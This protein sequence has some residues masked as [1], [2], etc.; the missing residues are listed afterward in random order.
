MIIAAICSAA[1]IVLIRPLIDDI[2]SRNNSAQLTYIAALILII[3]IIKAISEYFQ[4][5]II[6]SIGQKILTDIQMLLFDHLLHADLAFIQSE[7]SGKIISRLTN[8]INLVRGAVSNILISVARDFLTLIA[9]LII[10]ISMEP[11]LSAIVFVSFPVAI[12][13]IQFISKRM[14]QI[15]YSTQEN[16]SQYSKNLDEVFLSI[17]VVK[18]YS[19][20]EFEAKKA[21]NITDQILTLYKK[22]IKLESIISPINEIVSS[23]AITAILVYGGLSV[24]SGTST[25]GSLLTFIAA[26][27][28]AYKP[29]KSL[30]T[31]N[32]NLQEAVAASSRIFSALDTKPITYDLPNANDAEFASANICFNNIDIR[33]NDRQILQNLN[34]TIPANQITAIVG[35]SGAGKSSII[36]L[37]LKFYLPDSGQILIDDQ[38][39][40]TIK[41]KSLR[42]KIALVTQE[43]LLFD[44]SIA[45]NISYTTKATLDQ[46]IAAAKMSGAHDFIMQ[47]SDKYDTIIGFQG[48][49]LSGGQKQ[50]LSL[51]RAFLK[52]AQILVLDEATSSLDAHNERIIL[53]SINK[54]SKNITT[55]IVTHKLESI[56]NSNNIVV[57]SNGQIAEQGTHDQ[58]MKNRANYYLLYQEQNLNP[59]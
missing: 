18:S 13:C 20:E 32:V 19:G 39:I 46:I 30:L 59:Q 36:N 4:N 16:L 8:D 22:A 48:Y 25:G 28:S 55:I 23:L 1:N 57:V 5:Y 15:V 41:S 2:F 37:L 45:E 52:K 27:I 53:N 51:A 42:S 14:R 6:R 24:I 7:S 47:L 3:S 31:L 50:R 49:R 35:E 43:V 21:K 33:L 38:N 17:K 54:I 11:Q 26:F 40:A 9:L 12:Y 44:T 58:L 34:F 10:M 56:K 29:F